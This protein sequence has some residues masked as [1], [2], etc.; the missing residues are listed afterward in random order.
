[1]VGEVGGCSDEVDSGL[2]LMRLLRE[3]VLLENGFTGGSY[4][5]VEVGVGGF[6]G[7]LG[8]PI[9][10]YGVTSD[11]VTVPVD[12]RDESVLSRLKIRLQI[13][14]SLIITG[15]SSDENVTFH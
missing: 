13:E 3:R 10:S 11:K 1:M 4:E 12:L 15:S 2:V 7:D 9:A 14:V 8:G 5:L 6:E